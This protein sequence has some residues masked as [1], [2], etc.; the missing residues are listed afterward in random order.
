MS[1]TSL[2]IKTQLE[3]QFKKF[4]GLVSHTDREN[5][6]DLQGSDTHAINL[7]QSDKWLRQANVLDKKITTTD[8]GIAFNKFKLKYLTFAQY[9]EF[10]N[11]LAKA[12]NADEKEIIRKLI[13]CGEPGKRLQN[14]QIQPKTFVS[15]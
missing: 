7:N 9:E 14:K 12:K 4:S 11:N 10:L 3:D 1:Q 5:R 15:I 13:T 8:T 6:S 2:Q